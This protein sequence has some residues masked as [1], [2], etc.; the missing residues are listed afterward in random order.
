MSKR[1][2]VVARGGMGWSIARAAVL[3]AYSGVW[4]ED[5]D[6]RAGAGCRLIEVCV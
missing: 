2:D 6:Y 3:N 4:F 1:G 5:R